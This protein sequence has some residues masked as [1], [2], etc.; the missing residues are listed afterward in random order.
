M[1]GKEAEEK[2]RKR[3][4]KKAQLLTALHNFLAGADRK[5]IINKNNN[6]QSELAKDDS[7][8]NSL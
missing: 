8:G 6:I 1:W 5:K 2:I 4:E 3:L 7:L